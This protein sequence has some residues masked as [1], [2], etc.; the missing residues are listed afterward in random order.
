M[1]KSKPYSIT[2]DQQIT[3][4]VRVFSDIND[5]YTLSRHLGYQ[6][7]GDR[8]IYE[9][10]GYPEDNQ[11]Y[12]EDY[13]KRYMRQG[14]ATAIIDRPVEGTWK[15]EIAI[16]EDGGQRESSKLAEQWRM[17]DKNFKMKKTLARL[18]TLTGLG[19]YGVLLFGFNDIS[20]KEDWMNPLASGQKLNYIR[21]L[22]EIDATPVD[23]EKRSGDPRF[24]K[25]KFYEIRTSNPTF[26]TSGTY[27]MKVHHTRVLHI[28]DGSLSGSLLGR[29]RMKPIYNR[30]L[31][32]EKLMGGSAEMF[33]RGARPGYNINIPKDFA[34]STAERANL[35][36]EMK[37]YEDD[38]RRFLV[39]KGVDINELASQ[40][41]DPSKHVDILIQE[42]SA[43]SQIPKRI[44]TGS[45]RGEL[46]S[47]QDRD[48][49]L[50]YLK[51]RREEFAEDTIVR[52]VVDYLMDYGVIKEVSDYM[53][54]WEDMFALSEKDRVEIGKSRSEALSKVFG[55]PGLLESVGPRTLL[56]WIIGLG[57][58]ELEE[59]INSMEEEMSKMVREADGPEEEEEEPLTEE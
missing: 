35:K 52:P 26:D 48:A 47:S 34:M 44:L 6:Y 49:W 46:S 15:G 1:D 17:L 40:V 22:S 53:V 38:L 4:M 9:A 59:F 56:S 43:Y 57:D 2:R 3:A 21:A 16:M 18:D 11:I 50:E 14:I 30:L 58:D 23:F 37:A 7:D 8:K 29:P 33:W 25:P 27:E 10:L 24:G 5:R 28:T 36:T 55:T 41:S 12:F 31:D 13:L 42:V 39:T 51:Q 19:R 20:N 54:I 32:L 45:E